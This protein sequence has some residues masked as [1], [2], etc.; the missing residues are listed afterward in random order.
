LRGRF[1]RE[2]I[3][4][5]N[6]MSL[7]RVAA[8]PF[9]A[10]LWIGLDWR[11]AGLGLGTLIGLS[12]QLDGYVARRLHQT[13]ELGALIDQLGDLVFESTCIIIALVS[14][15]LWSGWLVVYLLREFTVTVIRSYVI[16]HGGELPSTM[17]GKVK[18]SCIQWA[19]FGIFLGGI[20]V[21]PGVVPAS[22]TMVG[23]SPGRMI[24]WVSDAWIVGG[25]AV[26]IVGAAIYF[27]SFVQFYNSQ[28]REEVGGR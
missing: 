19:M 8:A 12:D 13:T 3:T 23:I 9:L 15:Y 17:L 2:L 24:I 28:Q 6:T 27:R 21:Q 26:G 22:W 20:L 16:G 25:I 11:V 4:V 7:F 10:V 18:S 5:P 1:L 14:G